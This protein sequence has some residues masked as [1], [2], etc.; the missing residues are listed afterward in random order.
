[1]RP[2]QLLAPCELL[3]CL[4]ATTIL[5]ASYCAAHQLDAALNAPAE[6]ELIRA[7]LRLRL[8]DELGIGLGFGFGLV[9]QRLGGSAG[10]LEAIWPH[11]RVLAK[12]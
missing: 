8:R 6:A 5:L 4:R 12:P 11:L 2:G 9:L 1:M 3:F 7:R 10:D